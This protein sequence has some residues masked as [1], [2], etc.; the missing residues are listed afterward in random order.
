MRRQEVPEEEGYVQVTIG[1][2][3]LHGNL[4]IPA[5]AIG[6]VAFAHGSGSGRHSPRNQYVAKLLRDSGLATLLFDLLTLEEEAE[7]LITG[8]AE[9]KEDIPWP[10][11]SYE[12]K[13]R[14]G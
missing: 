14:Q 6:L 1:Q 10:D 11:E 4:L 9:G 8:N 5:K 2:T 13:N 7:D 12:G 3:I